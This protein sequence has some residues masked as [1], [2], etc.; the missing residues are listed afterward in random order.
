[1]M[2]AHGIDLV[3]IPSTARLLADPTGQFLATC[4]TDTERADVPAGTEQAARLSGRF[5]VKEAVL[6]ALG[7]GYGAGTS[8][9]DVEVVLQQSGAPAVVL[10]GKPRQCADA[11]G[12]TRWLVTTSHE[13]DMAIASVIAL[14]D[15]AAPR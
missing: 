6:K 5:A 15:Q 4:F 14:G 13:G 9:R 1:M 3:D 8:F 2:I 7:I 12:I 10:H 11:L